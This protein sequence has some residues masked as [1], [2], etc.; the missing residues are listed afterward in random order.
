MS[1]S[2]PT[3]DDFAALLEESFSSGHSGEGQ[4]VR[5]IVTAIE[6]DMAVIDDGLK[7]ESCVSFK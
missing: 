6:K 5:G 4:V 2:V 1:Q 3:R 7:V